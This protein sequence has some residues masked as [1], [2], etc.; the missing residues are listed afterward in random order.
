MLLKQ[1]GS[2]FAVV[3]DDGHTCAMFTDAVEAAAWAV[4]EFQITVEPDK[5][6]GIEIDPK[7]EKAPEEENE[8]NTRHGQKLH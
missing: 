7:T 2:W 6:F 4:G 1:K 3:D 5:E 8:G